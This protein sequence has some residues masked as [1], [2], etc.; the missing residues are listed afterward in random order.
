MIGAGAAKVVS[1]ALFELGGFAE[2]HRLHHSDGVGVAF[3][4]QFEAIERGDADLVNRGPEFIAAFAGEDFEVRG[5]AGRGGPIDVL[6]GQEAGE[7]EGPGILEVAGD[8]DLA[9]D[10]DFLAVVE[11]RGH[12][13]ILQVEIDADAG[14][15][16]QFQDELLAA[17]GEGGRFDDAAGECEGLAVFGVE[18]RRRA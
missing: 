8:A 4:E 13:A 6:A 17:F 2:Q 11:R 12:F 1:P 18:L 9:V 15:R 14:A 7:I 3:V 5:C 16:G 10:L